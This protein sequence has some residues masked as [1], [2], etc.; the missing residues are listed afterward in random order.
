MIISRFTYS[1]LFIVT[2]CLI[3]ATGGSDDREANSPTNRSV[4]DNPLI[5]G[6]ESLENLLEYHNIAPEKREA[7]ITIMSDIAES[8]GDTL[9]SVEKLKKEPSFKSLRELWASLTLNL[10]TSNGGGASTSANVSHPR[11]SSGQN[12]E[13]SG[14]SQHSTQNTQDLSTQSENAGTTNEQNQFDERT[15]SNKPG[16][17]NVQQKTT[18]KMIEITKYT[19]K[20]T[21]R[22]QLGPREDDR[23]EVRSEN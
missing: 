15:P 1:L 10:L 19:R 17:Y 3:A 14:T 8:E 20:T 12:D 5:N 9:A 6:Q 2:T 18:T 23:V 7:M 11:N 22:A 13:D 4:N 21:T 16:R